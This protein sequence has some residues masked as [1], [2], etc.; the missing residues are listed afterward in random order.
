MD[1]QVIAKPNDASSTSSGGIGGVGGAARAK[2]EGG[3]ERV[4]RDGRLE[5]EFG[6]R[7]GRSERE[8]S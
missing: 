4:G 1:T 2:S 6:R 3:M 8:V 7:S 5:G